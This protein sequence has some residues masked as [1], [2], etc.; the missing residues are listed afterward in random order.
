MTE[1]SRY[2]QLIVGLDELEKLPYLVGQ[3]LLI[4]YIH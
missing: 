3:F 4:L 1:K 2:H